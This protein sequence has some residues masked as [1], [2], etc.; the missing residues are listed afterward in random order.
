MNTP[1]PR[2]G[3]SRSQNVALVG[4]GQGSLLYWFRCT[5]PV[6][7]EPMVSKS[8]KADTRDGLD[9]ARWESNIWFGITNTRGLFGD[10]AM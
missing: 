10:D 6:G 7:P 3:T 1:T 2:Q 8:K 9:V 5:A 4:A